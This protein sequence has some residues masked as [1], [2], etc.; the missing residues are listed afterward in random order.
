MNFKKINIV[1]INLNNKDGLEKTIKSVISQTFFDKI[2]YIIIDGGSTDGSIDIIEKYKDYLS[3]YVSE[4]DNG[5]FHAMNKGVSVC[6]GEYV[7]FLNSGD[8]LHSND[9]IE[10]IYDELTEDVVYGNMLVE[11]F[12]ERI[13]ITK[14]DFFNEW[15]MP[16]PS[17]FT[18]VDLLLSKKLDENYKI[19]SD[20]IYYYEYMC[21]NKLPYKHID[22]IVS[23]FYIGGV[24]S[25]HEECLKEEKIYLNSIKEQS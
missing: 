19:I 10:K 18:K 7:Q 5:I 25:N 1:T 24:S 23:D 12:G 22:L 17:T 16:H 13:L 2:N 3:Y 21:I 9:V 8:N 15:F 11:P 20:W 6:S 4:C 14:Y